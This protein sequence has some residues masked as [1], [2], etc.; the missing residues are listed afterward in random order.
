MGVLCDVQLTG[1]GIRYVCVPCDMHLQV[2]ESDQWVSPVA[3][4]LQVVESDKWVSPVTYNLEVVE[5][6]K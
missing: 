5:S 1:G 4:N 3:Y 2:V 6:D